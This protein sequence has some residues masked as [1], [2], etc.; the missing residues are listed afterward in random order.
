MANEKVGSANQTETFPQ[1]VEISKKYGNVARFL[2]VCIRKNI[3]TRALQKTNL[4]SFQ[5]VPLTVLTFGSTYISNAFLIVQRSIVHPLMFK[6]LE[7][8]KL[9]QLT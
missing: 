2:I 7:T 4:H 1:D 5:Q 6:V 9:K 8:L 3:E